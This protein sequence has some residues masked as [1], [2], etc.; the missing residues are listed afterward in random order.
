M[1]VAADYTRRALN[2]EGKMFGL[3]GSIPYHTDD[4]SIK[5]S[6]SHTVSQLRILIV[7]ATLIAGLGVARFLPVDAQGTKAKFKF[8]K[9]TATPI[10]LIKAKKDF[11]VELLYS[12]PKATQGSWISM[13]VD[14]KGRLIVSD[15]ASIKVSKTG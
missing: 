11:K 10:E 3:W 13:T 15:Q 9:P 4:R 7:A 8:K 2:E 5:T 12:V 6:R 1:P 14:S